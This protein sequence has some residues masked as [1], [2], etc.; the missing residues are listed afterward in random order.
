MRAQTSFWKWKHQFY[1]Y[2]YTEKADVLVAFPF[3]L[4]W[5][6]SRIGLVYLI[7]ADE[8]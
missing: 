2:T 4:Q 5:E 7:R 3:F 6:K 1:S 8:P